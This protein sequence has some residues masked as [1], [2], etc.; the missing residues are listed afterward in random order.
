MGDTDRDEL[1]PARPRAL[2]A[3]TTLLLRSERY[4]LARVAPER[5]A[6][7][8]AL[9]GRAGSAFAAL[10][11]DGDGVSLTLP[12]PLWRASALRERA[13]GEQGPLRVITLDLAL[14]PDV[15]GYLAP[16]AARLARAGVPIVP[17]CG[18]SKDHL[19]VPEPHAERALE[20]LRGLVSDC[21]RGD[22]RATAGG[23]R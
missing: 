22:A 18:Y 13:H 1:P 15:T 3:R 11:V 16:A 9:A 14:E 20:V 6:E 7:A 12:E 17:Q 2:W 19:L 4:T 21:A 23:G 8:A 5:L 10:V